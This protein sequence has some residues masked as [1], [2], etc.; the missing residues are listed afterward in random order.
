MTKHAKNLAG[1]M[2]ILKAGKVPAT[3]GIEKM[4][5]PGGIGLQ[6]HKPTLIAQRILEVPKANLAFFLIAFERR[7]W[8]TLLLP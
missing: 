7:L 5:A 6:L 2:Q 4:I 1:I 3:C 8:R